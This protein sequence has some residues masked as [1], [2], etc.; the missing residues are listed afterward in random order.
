MKRLVYFALLVSLVPALL[1][2]TTDRDVLLTS[3][4]TLYT[5]ESDS[6]ANYGL[7][8]PSTRVLKLTTRQAGENESQFVP[9]TLNGGLHSEPALAYLAE[10]DTLFAV[11]QKMPNGSGSE[12]VFASYRDGKWS[13]PTSI[14]PA[15][16]R[17]R[18]NLRI[19]VTRYVEEVQSDEST[20]R[21]H[22][23]VI[24]LVWWEESS[25]GQKA[26]YAMLAVNDGKVQSI[27]ISDLET[28]VSIS[29]SPVE[30][31]SEVSR[32]LLV[33]PIIFER[34]S[35]DAVEV[36]FGDWLRA[37][38]YRVEIAPIR[39]DGVLRPP[40]GRQV[41]ALPAPRRLHGDSLG[42]VSA[43][44]G[45][46]GSNRLVLYFR[47]ENLVS[48]LIHGDEGWSELKQIAID[49][50]ITVEDAVT[51]LRKMVASE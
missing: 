7:S 19:G 28:F 32:E 33:Q 38:M 1:A 23:T 45:P 37:R 2:E 34:S 41:R 50:A 9:A 25:S 48:Y 11:W 42:K 17:Y 3:A 21:T 51:A 13:A 5:I 47:E 43:I 18:R 16:F 29:E 36:L 20:A 12:L 27:Q 49:S 26:R 22:G 35:N 46:A 14:D 40:I 15:P 8:V 31:S 44:D 24:H 4:G 39:A 10:T 30:D 6:V